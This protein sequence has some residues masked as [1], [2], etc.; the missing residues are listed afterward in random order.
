[1]LL[2][3]HLGVHFMWIKLFDFCGCSSIPVEHVRFLA[4]K[5]SLGK[6]QEIQSKVKPNFKLRFNTQKY[7][8]TSSNKK[9][10]E[11]SA[12]LLVT[13]ALL[14]VTR[15]ERRNTSVSLSINGRFA[16]GPSPYCAPVGF[17]TPALFV[18]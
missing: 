11:T 5:L 8:I 12:T 1:M 9:L 4:S 7:V 15:S 13:S 3:E 14:V 10:V 6:Q 16:Y 2:G 17:A 18:L